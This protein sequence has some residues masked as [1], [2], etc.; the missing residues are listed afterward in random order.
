MICEYKNNFL[1][2][3]PVCTS[4]LAG[5]EFVNEFIQQFGTPYY[6]FV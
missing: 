2:K 3:V 5:Q 4:T 1:N 6:E